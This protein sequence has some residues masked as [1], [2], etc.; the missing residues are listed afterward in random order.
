[1]KCCAACFEPESS[2]IPFASEAPSHGNC[3]FC[4]S[5]SVDVWNPTAFI[6]AFEP[7]LNSYEVAEGGT[8]SARPIHEQLKLDW[9][10]F[11]GDSAATHDSLLRAVFSNGH[12]L[13]EDGVR[14]VGLTRV[15]ST[16][17]QAE[18]WEEFSSEIT[19][20][21]RYF[22]ESLPDHA[23]LESVVLDNIQIL[24]AGTSLYRARVCVDATGHSAD[25]MGMPA[26]RD[27]TP[28]RANPLGIPHLYVAL[29]METCVYECRA[30][31]HDF[32]SVAEFHVS[33]ETAVGGVRVLRLDHI[34]EANP[35]TEEQGLAAIL[36]ATKL[37]RLLGRELSLPVRGSDNRVDYVPTQYLSEFVRTMESAP[38][39]I[40]YPSSIRP[41]GQ[42]LV[43]FTDEFVDL[44]SVHVRTITEMQLGHEAA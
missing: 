26:A 32:V 5:K 14:V 7:L 11:S 20:N 18:M 9:G 30:T 19:Q 1:M 29:D 34:P 21:R 39:G 27:A 36:Q 17:D 16:G 10:I 2:P 44:R 8:T 13:L 31:L 22:P 40:V 33:T 15:G 4:T 25:A 42:N 38:D 43:L 24:E 37:L 28:G 3:D 6:D 41:G 35:F 12:P 23:F